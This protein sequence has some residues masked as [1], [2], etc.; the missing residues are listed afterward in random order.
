MCASI[1]ERACEAR[2]A[3]PA[4]VAPRR[5]TSALKFPQIF[6][7]NGNESALRSYR[8]PL[9]IGG[10]FASARNII[11]YIHG[12]PLAF[13]AMPKA[14]QSAK[15]NPGMYSKGTKAKNA[16]EKKVHQDAVHVRHS[17]SLNST[18]RAPYGP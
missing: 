5:D 1:P 4:K 7:A 13:G 3:R 16:A 18:G 12:G 2:A 14:R 11:L 10:R 17:L 15:T 8:S 6:S 9:R